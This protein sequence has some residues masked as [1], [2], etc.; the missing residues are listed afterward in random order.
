[1]LDLTFLGEK[2]EYFP[3]INRRYKFK[4]LRFI[5]WVQRLRD[6][7]EQNDMWA[8]DLGTKVWNNPMEQLI[9]SPALLI[10]D[11]VEW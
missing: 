2:I 5:S 11:Y 9:L 6:D 3:S 4:S 10:E 1:M 8:K 7:P